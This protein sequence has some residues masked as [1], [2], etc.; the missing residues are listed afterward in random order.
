MWGHGLAGYIPEAVERLYA[1][2]AGNGRVEVQCALGMMYPRGDEI[3]QD[4]KAAAY[5]C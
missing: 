3:D 1:R 4:D 5:L 2:E